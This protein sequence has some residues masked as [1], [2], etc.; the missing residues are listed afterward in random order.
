M[1]KEDGPFFWLTTIENLD[2]EREIA[3]DRI[4][5]TVY[6]STSHRRVL[7]YLPLFSDYFFLWTPRMF[8]TSKGDQGSF[9]A[10]SI[11]KK[12]NL[13]FVPLHRTQLYCVTSLCL[14]LSI[15]FL[16]L[17]LSPC[18]AIQV[19]LILVQGINQNMT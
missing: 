7:H 2:R 3:K 17:F 1:K 18:P 11:R 5:V 6:L 16:V 19:H 12:R 14:L 8:V 9:L 13:R 15:W 4:K 10:H